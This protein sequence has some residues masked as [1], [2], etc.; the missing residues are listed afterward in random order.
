MSV[1]TQDPTG[2]RVV[3]T[4]RSRGPLSA[5]V[6]EL[7]DSWVARTA[8]TE[9]TEALMCA[10]ERLDEPL[11]IG[12]AG[13]SSVGKSTVANALLGERLAPTGAADTTRVVTYYRRGVT[14]RAEIILRDGAKRQIVLEQDGS[15]PRELPVPLTEVAAIDVRVP[16]CDVLDE[17]TLVDTPGISNLAREA[18]GLESATLL[19][20]EIDLDALIFL[21]H[22]GG[23]DELAAIDELNE[24]IGGRNRSPL[25]VIGVLNKADER[26]AGDDPLKAS[27]EF[28]RQLERA[29]GPR[30]RLSCVVPLIG[31]MAETARTGALRRRDYGELRRLLECEDLEWML[32]APDLFVGDPVDPAR[33]RLL[34][35]LRPHGLQVA[36]AAL[37]DGAASLNEVQAA[38]LAGSGLEA[39]RAG[40]RSK[41]L[42]HTDMIKVD[43]AIRILDRLTFRA[44]ASDREGFRESLECLLLD[45]GLRAVKAYRVLREV[46]SG[47]VE[48]P[49]WLEQQLRTLLTGTTPRAQ[50]GLP[51]TASRTKALGLAAATARRAQV[52]AGGGLRSSGEV[53]AAIIVIKALTSVHRAL[54]YERAENDG[55]H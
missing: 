39:L 45:P 21:F 9:V 16:Y 38:L 31:V 26:Y 42:A 46:R 13:R 50:L 4:A 6:M 49:Q 22:R 5:R 33:E 44:P 25:D 3:D 7:I 19:G 47:T 18:S 29:D 11:R 36:L 32:A 27:L 14:E 48:L 2:E 12:L 52:C 35:L 34:A 10:R 51:A 55:Q 43:R 30:C 54:S 40:L 1:A 24:Q 37:R 15:L 41:F 17:L 53:S 20:T 23:S 28:A 8:D